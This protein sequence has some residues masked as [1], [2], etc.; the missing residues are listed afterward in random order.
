MY[1]L[2]ISLSIL[3]NQQVPFEC[4]A[5]SCLFHTDSWK[6]N[7]TISDC[8][9]CRR[10]LRIEFFECQRKFQKRPLRQSHFGKKRKIWFLF[11]VNELNSI[12]NALRKLNQNQFVCQN[13][14]WNWSTNANAVS[15]IMSDRLRLVHWN[16]LCIMLRLLSVVG[17]PVWFRFYGYAVFMMKNIPFDFIICIRSSFFFRLKSKQLF[18]S[19]CSTFTIFF[20]ESQ[21]R[22][23][24]FSF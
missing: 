13:L 24:F 3:F 2:S 10:Q 9:N 5:L 7:Y 18:V 20:V 19:V 15:S 12:M 1:R 22:G 11:C 6:N 16:I 21:S 14:R 23:I 8:K 17:Y 4:S